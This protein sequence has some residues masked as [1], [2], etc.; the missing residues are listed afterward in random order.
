[1][2]WKGLTVPCMIEN[3]EGLRLSSEFTIRT[4]IKADIIGGQQ[5]VFSKRV[6]LSTGN[7]PGIFVMLRGSLIECLT[8]ENNSDS[9]ITCRTVREVIS[10]GQKFEI[11]IFRSGKNMEIYI[12]GVKRTHPKY[13]TC[14]PGD[15]NADA[16]I[17]VG[18]QLYDTEPVS[19]VFTGKIYE[20]ELYDQA[21][22]SSASALRYPKNPFV[23]PLRELPQKR[24]ELKL[25]IP[26]RA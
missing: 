4:L 5:A 1:M 22:Y 16:P 8:F 13:K 7:R 14:S 9:W 10:V 3:S 6:P 15:I 2:E 19:E 25:P 21:Y 12:N 26:M 17:F 18:A 20:L 11:L 23:F 24:E